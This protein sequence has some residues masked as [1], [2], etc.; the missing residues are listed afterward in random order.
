MSATG[1]ST[2][3]ST[4][5]KT[6]IWLDD[7]M[8][9]LHWEGQREKAYHALGV[10]LHTLRDHLTIDETAQLAAQ[11]PQMIRGMYYE[12]W[13][14]STVPVRERHWDQFVSHVGEA[15][16]LDPEADPDEIT[17]AVLYVL[18]KHVSEGEIADVLRCLPEEYLRHWRLPR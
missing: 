17:R 12:G 13:K 7:I 9:K 14:P 16:A 1:L 10:V 11:L 8:R 3:D 6:N 18:A 2:F 5:Q 15:F 4:I